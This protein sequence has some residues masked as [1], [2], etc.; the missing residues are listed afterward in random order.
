MRYNRGMKDQTLPVRHF[1]FRFTPLILALCVGGVLLCAA[2]FG[3]STWQFVDFVRT[4][5]LTSP[6]EWIKYVLWYGASLALSA[7]IVSMLIR[8][9]YTLDDDTLTVQFGFVKQ[10]FAISKIYSVH[11]FRGAKKLAVYFDDFHTDYIGIV[12]AE[13]HWDEFVRALT[14]RS[15]RIG[16]TFSTAEEEEQFKK[17]K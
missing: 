1:P 12:I 10:R 16:F 14:E 13:E 5:D 6:Y 7:F 8:S 4:G 17:K 3:F 15:P 11:L 9:R 2:S